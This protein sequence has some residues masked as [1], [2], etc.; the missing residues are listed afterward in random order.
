M[1][2]GLVGASLVLVLGAAFFWASL[3]A[4]KPF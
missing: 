4:S 2:A 3:G 1:A